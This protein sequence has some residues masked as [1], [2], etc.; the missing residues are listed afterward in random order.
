MLTRKLKTEFVIEMPNYISNKLDLD[1]YYPVYDFAFGLH[2]FVDNVASYDPVDGVVPNIR[3]CFA[4]DATTFLIDH[5][6]LDRSRR[7]HLP[8]KG[9]K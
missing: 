6:A 5:M 1:S 9:G 4:S 8:K 3:T 7:N 2:S